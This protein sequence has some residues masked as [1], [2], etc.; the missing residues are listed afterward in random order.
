[1]AKDKIEVQPTMLNEMQLHLLEMFSRKKMSQAEMEDIKRLISVYYYNKF[2]DELDKMYDS[3]EL[4]DE[5]REKQLN[6]HP[7]RTPYKSK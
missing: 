4:S 1:M 7:E 2:N 5:E 6:T 3:G